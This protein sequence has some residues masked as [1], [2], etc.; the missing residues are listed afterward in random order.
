MEFVEK[1]GPWAVVA[2]ASEGVGAE[3]AEAL[4]GRGLNVVLIARRQAALDEVAARIRATP[5]SRR[6]CW[7]STWPDRTPRPR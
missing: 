6:A 4:A 7:H 3:F 5:G 2:G 1:Y